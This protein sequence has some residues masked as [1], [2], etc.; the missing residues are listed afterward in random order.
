[1]ASTRKFSIIPIFKESNSTDALLLALLRHYRKSIASEQEL[2]SSISCSYL[3]YLTVSKG[4][5][6]KANSLQ[7]VGGIGTLVET[8]DCQ[9]TRVMSWPVIIRH[10]DCYALMSPCRL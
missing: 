9:E 3:F 2:I 1:M 7:H 8:S 10:S 4:C 5:P 6:I